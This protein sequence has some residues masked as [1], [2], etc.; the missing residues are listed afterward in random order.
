MNQAPIGTPA[1]A[2]QLATHAKNLTSPSANKRTAAEQ[3]LTQMNLSPAE[4]LY[5][6][7][8]VHEAAKPALH[9]T[10]N[11]RP[12]PA[13]RGVGVQ[14]T[15]TQGHG[16]I[17]DLSHGVPILAE[18][19]AKAAAKGFFEN[20]VKY[21]LHPSVALQH[22]N[23]Q[24][25]RSVAE[26]ATGYQLSSDILKRD[27]FLGAGFA[28]A[29][30]LPF[31][32]IGEIGRLAEEGSLAGKAAEATDRASNLTGVRKAIA[33]KRAARLTL[34]SAR[35]TSKEDAQTI[36]EQQR[37]DAQAK[38]V[39]AA[40]KNPVFLE[41]LPGEVRAESG[42]AVGLKVR[43]AMKG[44]RGIYKQ[45]KLLEQPEVAARASAL[46]AAQKAAGSFEESAGAQKVL[47]GE[48]PKARFDNFKSL[49][50]HLEEIKTYVDSLNMRAHDQNRLMNAI[51]AGVEGRV[52]N[53]SQRKLIEG[54]FGK[55]VKNLSPDAI[56]ER[57][58]GN[59]L[60]DVA[61]I[62]RALESSL[63]L[64]GA[65]RQNLA[66]VTYDPIGVLRG[67]HQTLHA[68]VS[69]PEFDKIMAEEIHGHPYYHMAK[70]DGVSITELHQGLNQKEEA[71][72]SNMAEELHMLPGIRSVPGLRQVAHGVSAVVKG[73]DRNY[74]ILLDRTR[75]R[76]YPVDG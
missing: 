72:A 66:A 71:F 15:G 47:A 51:K 73:S 8:K 58:I 75:M 11:G 17:H 21:A 23:E 70:Q 67:Y 39:K 37:Q 2:K 43:E 64:S 55:E 1:R 65:L 44:A 18:H 31:G 48:L 6:A 59:T 49:A 12:V 74:M 69:Q 42:G 36:L 7:S 32:K 26:Q 27:P 9:T 61:N 60:T 29:G 57:G 62:P 25:G 20:P 52:P 5:V 56:R 33:T 38:A 22:Q 4:H 13:I 10:Q 45:Q 3:H 40:R 68:A 24:F 76:L 35:R 63:D 19:A 16:F 28:A 30:L 41:H 46:K 50:P 53:P 34:K 14:E 54:V